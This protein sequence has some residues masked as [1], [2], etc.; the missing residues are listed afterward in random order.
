MSRLLIDYWREWRPEILRWS[1]AILIFTLFAWFIIDYFD[2]FNSCLNHA[3]C[4]T[5]GLG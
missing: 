5:G 4:V 1:A 3:S 2:Y